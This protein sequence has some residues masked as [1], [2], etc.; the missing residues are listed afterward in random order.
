MTLRRPLRI[1]ERLMRICDIQRLAAASGGTL[2]PEVR[3][4]NGCSFVYRSATTP[5]GVAE[6]IMHPFATKDGRTLRAE[7]H[8]ALGGAAAGTLAVAIAL[9]A[10]AGG[11]TARLAMRRA[12]GQGMLDALACR[13]RGREALHTAMKRFLDD[14]LSEA[15][16]WLPHARQVVAAAPP[17]SPL[18]QA[19]RGANGAPA[20]PLLT[21]AQQA[22]PPDAPDAPN[23]ADG[24]DGAPQ[25]GRPAGNGD[26]KSVV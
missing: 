7:P 20:A 12:D 23:D 17:S 3:W 5:T 9:A 16:P 22:L 10:R 15:E 21:A 8:L 6:A 24:A 1:G 25:P 18:R 4:R 19:P 26:R 14:L 13:Y 11:S 2:D